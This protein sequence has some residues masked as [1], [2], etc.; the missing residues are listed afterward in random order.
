MNAEN[1]KI[2]LAILTK[3]MAGEANPQEA[4]HIDDWLAEPAN[5]KEFDSLKKLWSQLSEGAV[6]QPLN[7]EHTWS[8]LQK[9]LQHSKHQRT[10]RIQFYRYASAASV[11]GLL[12]LLTSTLFV[13][14]MKDMRQSKETL[15]ITTTAIGQVQK[16]VMPDGSQITLNE[17]STISYPKYF[18]KTARE[19]A[20]NG[21]CFFN[22][23][24]DKA[25][26]FVITIDELKIKV[27]GTSFNVRKIPA[28]ER[29]EVQVQ[30]GIVKMYTSQKEITVNRGK[31]GVY[32]IYNGALELKDTI[33]INSIGYATKI[34]SFNDISF[35]DACHYLESAFNVTIRIDALRYEGCKITAQFDNK[36]LEYIL[37]VITATLNTSYQKQEDLII[38]TGAGCQ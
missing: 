5:R 23:I 13:S 9:S 8:E 26:P 18:N 4:M 2:D 15:L 32:T 36:P 30:S 28:S 37:D 17:H 31:T 22:V 1:N 10:R 19:L 33:D 27:V 24:P 14:K 34:F 16:A 6:L 7:M 3:Y 25:R 11:T 29:I 35:I 21:E 12:V 38:V 20:L